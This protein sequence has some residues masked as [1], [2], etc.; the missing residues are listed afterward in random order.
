MS[1]W[2]GK[3]PTIPVATWKVGWH[4]YANSVN[5]SVM[6][7]RDLRLGFEIGVLC[8]NVIQTFTRYAQESLWT[9]FRVCYYEGIEQIFKQ[10]LNRLKITFR[11]LKGFFKPF[12]M[13][14]FLSQIFQYFFTNFL[15]TFTLIDKTLKIWKT[16]F[17][18]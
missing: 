17:L 2:T 6:Q 7:C 9:W 13:T 1:V 15:V 14:T 10:I 4:C 16:K 11:K 12:R 18:V 8:W 5:F 3:I